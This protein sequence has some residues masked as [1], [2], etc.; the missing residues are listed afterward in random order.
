MKPFC[1]LCRNYG[2]HFWSATTY[3]H[4]VHWNS[5]SIYHCCHLCP[6]T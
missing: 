6:C 3:W 5:V 4:D 1:C 2:H